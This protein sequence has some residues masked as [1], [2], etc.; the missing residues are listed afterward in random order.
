MINEKRIDGKKI[1]Q[2]IL[3]KL[4]TQ[5][6]PKKI[7]A[8]VLVGENQASVS[9]L[10]QK[11]KAAK[12]LGVD[13]RI[14][15]F[16]A[17][18]KNDKLR[19][20]VLKLALSKS[21][22]G[23]VVQLPLA[24]HLN[25]HYILNAIPREK[26]VDVLGERALGAFYAGRNLVLPPAVGVVEE[27]LI[28]NNLKLTTMRVAVIGLGL[29]VG[30]PISLWLQRKAKETFLLYRGSDFLILKEAELVITGIGH[31]GIIKPDM[32]REEA[33]IIDF[34]YDNGR[35]DFDYSASPDLVSYTP[36]PGGT[37]PIL[38]AKIFENFYKLT[39]AKQKKLDEMVRM[40]L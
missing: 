4:K 32:L 7:F 6:I 10:K 37:G 9:F 29:L 24:E 15:K 21:V 30:R 23:V 27:L 17:E 28:T 25:R 34:G 2:N 16:P 36:T 39:E 3:D 12:E 33:M 26:D 40:M 20:E 35:G 14:Y 31:A 22:G 13:F 8:A 38:V 11:E 5:P 1:A 19:E 18:I